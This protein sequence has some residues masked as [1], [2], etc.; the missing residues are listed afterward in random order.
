MQEAT[1]LSDQLLEMDLGF[2]C[3][4]CS[5]M[6]AL[7]C[8]WHI[9]P[10]TLEND[11]HFSSSSVCYQACSDLQAFLT[12]LFQLALTAYSPEFKLQLFSCWPSVFESG[13]HFTSQSE[14]TDQHRR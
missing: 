13:P 1:N 7:G 4:N 6:I 10:E 3:I 12:E 8:Y 9:N 5:K 11:V 2:K 14:G